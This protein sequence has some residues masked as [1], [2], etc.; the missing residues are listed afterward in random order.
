MIKFVLVLFS[1]AAQGLMPDAVLPLLHF[2]RQS[3]EALCSTEV[4]HYVQQ[5][6]S[7]IYS[8]KLFKCAYEDEPD[9]NVWRTQIDKI[10]DSMRH[11][12]K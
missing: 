2:I 11:C 9:K 3:I 4:I 7:T 6:R 1:D 12:S 8:G 10:T 5:K